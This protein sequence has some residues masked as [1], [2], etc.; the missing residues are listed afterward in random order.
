M[1]CTIVAKREMN[2]S[3]TDN[4]ADETKNAQFDGAATPEL[5]VVDV[6]Y[7]DVVWLDAKK[8]STWEETIMNQMS[9]SWG[10]GPRKVE[11][12]DKEI[13]IKDSSATY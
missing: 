12:L 8:P 2:K 3:K 13:I 7:K 4:A 6:Q 10:L 1:L 5:T 9:E 11:I